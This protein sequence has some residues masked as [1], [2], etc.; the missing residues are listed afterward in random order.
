M[1]NKMFCVTDSSKL[2]KMARVTHNIVCPMKNI[3]LLTTCLKSSQTL[4]SSP[5]LL[6]RHVQGF[7]NI[8]LST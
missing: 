3:T 4:A 6:H 5:G 8:M 7:F 2:S 1:L